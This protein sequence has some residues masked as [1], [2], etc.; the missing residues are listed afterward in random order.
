M[1]RYV[2]RRLALAI[3][4]LW[5]V[6]TVI[7][8][9]SY[10]MPGDPVRAVMGESY[11]RADPETIA[12]VCQRLGLDDP[13]YVQYVRFL[14]RTARGDLGDSYVLE[15]PV[16]DVIGY[17]FPRTLQLMA[18]GML[19]AVAV[20]L[21]A[22]IVAAERQY[23]WI[24]HTLMLL[25]LIGVAMP[26]FWQAI[27]AKMFLTQDRY[28]VALFPVAGYGGGELIYMVLPSLVL[29][30]HLSAT[31]ARITRSS[32]LEVR[33]QP[34]IVTA[35]A[36]GLSRWRVVLRHQLKNALVPVVT[37]IGL[38]VGYLMG[39]SVVTETVFNW[40]GL[41]RAV[42]AAIMRRDTPVILGTLLF[43]SLIFVTVNLLIDLTYALVNPRIRYE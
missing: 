11:R 30:T 10:L 1:L 39:G 24:D 43:G 28:G 25:A 21:P 27:L 41:G 2:I 8:V 36:K 38:D 20:G 35:S 42:V 3:P 23:T 15:Q 22:G 34:Y 32:M 18:G 37:V 6:F 33:S 12:R 31:I 29:G 14:G 7:F 13:W 19:V 26:V 5:G 17:R 40:P 4:T 16:R 9:L